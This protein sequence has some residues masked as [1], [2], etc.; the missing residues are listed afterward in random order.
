MTDGSLQQS[1]H[2]IDDDPCIVGLAM[3]QCRFVSTMWPQ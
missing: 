2:R 3:E 1:G